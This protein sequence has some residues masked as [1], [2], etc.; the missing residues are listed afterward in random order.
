MKNRRTLYIVIIILLLPLVIL[1][2]PRL[3]VLSLSAW[4]YFHTEE[5]CNEDPIPMLYLGF[6]RFS[7]VTDRGPMYPGDEYDVP[8]EGAWYGWASL[9]YVDA[10]GATFIVKYPIK[11]GSHIQR[12][13]CRW[14]LP[15]PE[16]P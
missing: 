2:I 14:F 3:I 10:K 8:A 13:F 5:I 7:V 6:G 16:D 1:L 12:R 15:R 9:L 4:H 11:S